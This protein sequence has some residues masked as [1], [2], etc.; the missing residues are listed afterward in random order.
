MGLKVC[1]FGG[2]SLA[3]ADQ[4]RKVRAIIEAD[5][6]RRITVVSAPGKRTKDDQKVTD[7]LLICQDLA[8]NGLDVA[9]VFDR[10]RERYCVIASEL[11]IPLDVTA[12]L[13]QVEQAIV[14]TP[15]R[16]FVASR[17]EYLCAQLMAAWLGAKFI[18]PADAIIFRDEG[19]IDPVTYE[20]LG[21]RLQ[22]DGLCI[23]P[24]FYGSDSTGRIKTFPRGGSD[25]TG[26]VTARAAKASLYENWTD[27]TGFRMADP[28][29][30]DNP[31]GIA[32]LTYRELRELAYMGAN[33]L[34]DEAT[35]PVRD[36][37][38]PIEILNTNAPDEPGTRI[39]AAR[40][41]GTPIVT[42]IAG[43]KDFVMV[44]MEKALMNKM[45][46]FGRRVL[47]IFEEH[48][49]SFDHTP[50]GIDTMSVVV[51]A[52]AL[53]DK[54]QAILEEIKRVL[55]PDRIELISELAIIATVGE[56]MAHHVGTAAKLFTALADADVNIRI[57]DQGSSEINIIVGVEN[58]DFETAIRAIY[59]AF[60]E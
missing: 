34:H 38:I 45:V 48:D 54:G 14:R 35:F 53:A 12:L 23:V 22:H 15:T 6:A 41:P 16:D 49:V 30:I 36:A 8:A 18:E 39:V 37:G 29:I 46:G 40:E 25:I 47:E 56:G 28:R 13:D 33:V 58:K 26:A 44:Q 31:R 59:H 55:E 21:A 4:F 43:V 17:G 24:G 32:E 2:T 52:E 27:V 3:D 42:G 50:T 10:V 19:H 11:D 57:I 1:K 5:P 60:V 9:Q 20:R 7:L 51:R